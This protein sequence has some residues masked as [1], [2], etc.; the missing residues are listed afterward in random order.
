MAGLQAGRRYGGSEKVR[1]YGGLVDGLLPSHAFVPVAVDAMGTWG[2]AFARYMAEAKAYATRQGRLDVPDALSRA[3]VT[4][5]RAAA[6]ANVHYF[7]AAYGR[8]G[9]LPPFP[10]SPG[11]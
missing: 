10:C 8:R 4:V 1:E 11:I 7:R 5:S 3:R 6:E 2:T 9:V